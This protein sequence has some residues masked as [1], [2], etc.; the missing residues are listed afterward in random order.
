[1][2][3]YLRQL[4]NDEKRSRFITVGTVRGDDLEGPLGDILGLAVTGLPD[5]SIVGKVYAVVTEPFAAGSTLDWGF[6]DAGGIVGDELLVGLDLTV[7]GATRSQKPDGGIYTLLGVT[8]I[9][10]NASAFASTVGEVKL[11]MELTEVKIKS[12]K[13]ST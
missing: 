2:A 8:G 11:C 7:V 13:Y 4:A 5:N 3:D 12:G 10:P 6:I 1:M 9:V